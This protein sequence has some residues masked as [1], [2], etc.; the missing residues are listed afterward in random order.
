M[1]YMYI[2]CVG[3]RSYFSDVF[4]GRE[5]TVHD[6]DAYSRKLA[7]TTSKILSVEVAIRY[8]GSLKPFQQEVCRKA[9]IYRSTNQCMQLLSESL[10]GNQTQIRVRLGVG[11]PLIDSHHAK[12][13]RR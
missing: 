10:Y 1:L 4:R 3:L 8:G 11:I 13:V 7:I 5:Q 12:A 6:N 9:Q 2:L